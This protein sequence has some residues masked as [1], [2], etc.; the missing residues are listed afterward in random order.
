MLLLNFALTGRVRAY[1]FGFWKTETAM[2][3]AAIITGGAKNYE[4]DISAEKAS[5]S[6]GSWLQS[7]NGY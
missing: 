3:R 2:I 5:E 6:K 1:L 4:N 7:K